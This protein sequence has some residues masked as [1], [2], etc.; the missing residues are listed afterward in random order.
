MSTTYVPVAWT[1]GK[2]R[3]DLTIVGGVVGYLLLFV[4]VSK[5]VW[6]GAEAISDE[7]LMLR[8]LGSC[9][10]ILLH[11]TL[12]IGPLV[13]LK[14][15]LA[16]V[17][18]NRRHLGVITFLVSAGHGLLSLG[19]YHGFGV[20]SPLRSL[21]ISSSDVTAIV[22]FPFE[23]LGVGALLILFVLA[24]TSHDFWL[25]QLGAR[26]WKWLH[27]LVYVAYGLVVLHVAMGPLAGRDSTLTTVLVLVGAS[28]L[29]VLHLI[30]G[31]REWG[32]DR[33]TVPTAKVESDV[34]GQWVDVGL[35]EEIPMNRARTICAAGGERIAVYRHGTTEQGVTAVT[36]V[37][38]HQG[39][40]LG[41][42]QVID[43][44]ITCPWHGW[45]YRASDG[46]A[47]P[48]FTEQLETFP[49]RVEEGRVLVRINGSPKVD[50]SAAQRQMPRN[51]DIANG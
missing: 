46:V 9:A 2:I 26:V 39:G 25:K 51:G 24:A 40:P 44:C 30:A 36:N 21:L 10:M 41:E 38:K 45:Q 27:M 22:G 4:V 29:G 28:Y 14:P 23:W 35:L 8:A 19:Y 17:L 50:G 37:C 43:G 15:S 7:V 32:I 49:V 47:P 13:R 3:Y 20:V 48:P 5:F 34:D 1:K 31:V 12:S 42:G 16:P 6:Q 18:F 33:K 11:I